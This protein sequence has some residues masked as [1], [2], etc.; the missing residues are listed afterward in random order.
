MQGEEEKKE[1]V[2]GTEYAEIRE[3][4]MGCKFCY[5]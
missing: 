3:D 5:E 2:A 4:F 1:N